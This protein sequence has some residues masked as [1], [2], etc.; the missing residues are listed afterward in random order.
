MKRNGKELILN[1]MDHNPVELIPWVPY[2]GVHAGFLKGFTA[3]EVLQDA[4]KLL[5]ALLEV[6]NRYLPDGQ[7]VCF[8]LQIE[9]EALGCGLQWAS[10][11]PP[12]VISHPLG[13]TNDIPDRMISREDGRIPVVLRACRQLREQVGEHTAIYGLFCG[14]FTLASHLR[15][16]QL[17]LD[18]VMNPQYVNR[19]I[20]YCSRI[21]MQMAGN[22]MDEDCDVIAPVDP[23]ISQISP[24]HFDQFC[25]AAYTEMFD[26]IRARNK[27]SSFFVCGNAI[28]NIEVMCQTGPDGISVDENVDLVAAREITDS[29]DLVIGGNI[30]TTTMM[31]YGTP[32]ETA[33]YVFDLL[34]TIDPRRN[35]ILSPGCDIPYSV[36]A[37]NVEAAARAALGPEGMRR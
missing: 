35:F 6:N 15:G 32:E 31:M 30:P 34:E 11:M 29:Y 26:L 12:S 10:D 17:F 3:Q 36:P 25:S 23:L 1:V 21:A 14:P 20:D 13:N 37:E 8:D 16:S 19:L 5:E 22:Y 24:K 2:T 28:K 18:M 9:A 4:D 33:Q 7:P 27:A